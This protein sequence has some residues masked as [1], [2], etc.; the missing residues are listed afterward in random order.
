MRATHL[1]SLFYFFLLI[2]CKVRNTK[3]LCDH[4][5]KLL[6]R[7]IILYFVDDTVSLVNDNN[8]CNVIVTC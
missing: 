1:I 4:Y 2:D 8:N 6:F 5:Y 3:S 7:F